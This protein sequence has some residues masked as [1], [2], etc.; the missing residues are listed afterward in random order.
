MLPGAQYKAIE[1]KTVTAAELEATVCMLLVLA[2]GDD[3]DSTA[4]LVQ[5]NST[6]RKELQEL[7]QSGLMPDAHL[8]DNWLER[9]RA[10]FSERHQ[11]VHSH[12]GMTPGGDKPRFPIGLHAAKG[13]RKNEA[14]FQ[15]VPADEDYWNELADT[16]E[17]LKR[18][19]GPFIGAAARACGLG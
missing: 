19:A 13:P 7:A 6:W 12:W 1:R 8:V 10:A 17:D 11:L 14:Q 9:C 15:L 2:T 3:R 4:M 18:E 5:P 16:F